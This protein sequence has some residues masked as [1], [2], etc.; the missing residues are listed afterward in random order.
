MPFEPVLF[1]LATALCWG[2]ADYLSRQQSERVGHY[3]TTVYMHVTTFVMLLTVFPLLNP[4]LAV[5]FSPVLLLA[6][7]GVLN[8]FAFML[9]YRA[10][11][12]GVVS[13]VAPI[14]YT[15]PAFTAILSVVFLGTAIVASRSLAIVGIILGVV[16]LS[17]RFSELRT[18]KGMGAS[19][20]TKGVGSAISSSASFGMVY[21]AIGYA[22]GFVGYILPVYILRG[23]GALVGF[24]LAPVL[25]QSVRPSRQAFSRVVLAMGVLESVG[26]LSFNY[27][28]TLG[29]DSLPVVAALSGMGGAVAAAYALYFLRERLELNQAIGVLLS[30]LGVF[31]LLYLGG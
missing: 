4:S 30:M 12:T 31:A 29:A 5:P 6:A 20:L 1:G 21:V 3:N 11:H 26:F 16:L 13:V 17:T 2:T 28:L 22:T 25:K 14:A 7:A 23:A 19:R 9:L 27:G 8:F 15:F 18:A 10:F 24:L